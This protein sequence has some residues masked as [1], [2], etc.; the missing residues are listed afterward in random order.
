MFNIF[1]SYRREDS[2]AHAGR[3]Y[4]RLVSHYDE[5][6]VFMDVD[7]VPLGVDFR[8]HLD[9]AVGKCNVLVV[10]IGEHWLEVCFKDGPKQGQR[11]LDDPTDFVRI[12]IVSALNRGI[13]V[14]PVMVGKASMPDEAA[15]PDCLKKLAFRNAA[16]V[17]SGRDFRDHVN[18][19][20]RG[21]EH[22]RKA[23]EEK[24]AEKQRQ[25]LILR[26]QEEA[27]RK[28][29]LEGKRRDQGE[30][31]SRRRQLERLQKEGETKLTQFV[32]ETLD[33]TKGKPTKDDSA[34]ATAICKQYRLDKAKAEQ[35]VKTAREQWQKVHRPKLE[36]VVIDTHGDVLAMQAE[37]Q[38]LESL[39][40][41]TAEEV[42]RLMQEVLN[43]LSQTEMRRGETKPNQSI[44]I[45]SDERTAVKQL[46]A[47]FRQLPADQQ[48]QAPALLNAL[49][50][51]QFGSADF[52]GARETFETVSQSIT[53]ATAQAEAQFNAYRAALEEKKWEEALAAIQK[54]ASLDSQRFAPFP[55][56]RYQPKRLLGAGGFGAAFLCHD[57]NFDEEV[58]VKTL[59]DAAMERNIA[60]VFREARLLRKLNHP[61]IIGV[62]ECE[63]ADPL[64]HAR[65]Y[66]VMDYFPGGSLENLIQQGGALP[67]N[68]LLLVARQVAQGLLA[69]HQQGI[70]HRD[71]KPDNVLVCKEGSNWKIKI[72]DFGLALRNPILA[73][74]GT[75]SA[76]NTFFGENVAGTV[77][78][79][80]PE[81]MGEMK[82]VKPG[83]YSDVFSF[84]KMCCY[85]LF[86]TT[87]PKDR[88]WKTVS[89]NIRSQLKD[90][91]DQCRE[92]ELEHRL[93][94]FEPVLNVLEA[95]ESMQSQRKADEEL[96]Q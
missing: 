6:A 93:P 28:A 71:I 72:I 42:R 1:I 62:H 13:P 4:D 36:T 49:G 63:Y 8:E 24:E 48:H 56:Q 43:R 59:H 53:D 84:G 23:N 88:H 85:A 58:V 51:L 54:A 76:R 16:E 3:I 19:L 46:L 94:S 9:Q 30:A 14:I 29:D 69:A 17:R 55:M 79:A 27:R 11:R 68:D 44:S 7:A 74:V 66:I 64:H 95:L 90:M 33:R 26:Q 21:I 25:E 89:D 60:E 92:E 37:L 81:Q 40:L 50:K 61:A 80:P 47:R 22:L 34:A 10:I 78:Y 32:R 39:N 38:R 83:P 87:E 75:H 86:K 52:E 45:S 5:K 20:I 2:E 70:L 77:K 15:L 41:G 91:L 67:T 73:T 82:G 12:E 31:D 65:P 96:K 18:R 57:R 35:I